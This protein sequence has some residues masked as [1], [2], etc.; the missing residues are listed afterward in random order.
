MCD[1]STPTPVCD[2]ATATITVAANTVTAVDDLATTGPAT[3]VEIPLLANDDVGN[4]G[5]ALAPASVVVTTPP[6]HGTVTIDPATGS[7]T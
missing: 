1:T 6:T 7:A 5:A 2:T 4:G 3:A